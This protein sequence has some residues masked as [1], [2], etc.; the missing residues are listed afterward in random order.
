MYNLLDKLKSWIISLFKSRGFVLILVFSIMSVILIQRVFVLQIVNGQDY[1][2]DY[3]LKIQKTREVQGTRGRILDRNGVVLADNKLAYAVTIEDNGDY[4]NI[5]EKNAI[6]NDTIGK[7]I[8][9]VESNGDSIISNFKI[10]LNDN[11]EYEYTMGEGTSRLRFLADIFGFAT[12]DKL[13][14][15]QRTM[16]AADIIDY[17]CT[18]KTYGYGIDQSSMSKEEV[19]KYVNIRYAMS[20][21]RFQ[22]YVATT[23]ASDVSEK[24]TAAIM[25]NIDML[26]GVNIAEDSLRVYND[27]KYFAS[28]I[29]YT[30]QISKTEYDNLDKDIQD[31]YSLTDTIGKSGLEQ[32]MDEYLKGEKGQ[33]KLYV[34]NVGKVIESVQTKESKA[35]ND[36][37]LTID[38]DLQKV[39]YDLLEEKLAGILIEHLQ[40]VLVI[41]PI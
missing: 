11:N 41:A 37:Y 13:D 32:V 16:S 18:N 8:E 39:A 17:L 25:E 20:L 33:I 1:L 5:K 23:I 30:G 2:E 38:A 26:Q 35:G 31:K 22:K 9:I 34:N 6:I 7:I 10:V 28:I 12:I 27:S 24:T 36:V 3:T 40:N 15:E 14:P 21:N 29:G 4:E 19:L